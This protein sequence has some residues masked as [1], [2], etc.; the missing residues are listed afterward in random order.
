MNSSN[1]YIAYYRVSTVQQGKSGLGLQAQ[2]QTVRTY[3]QNDME[4]IIAEFTDIESGKNSS[5]PELM[6]ALSM[7]KE[8]NA[9]LVVAKLDRLSRELHFITEIQK[10]GIEFVCADMPEANSLTLHIFGA[11]AQH[12]R[13]LISKRTKDALAQAKL[14]GK[15]LGAA[16][17]KI[18]EALRNANPKGANHPQVK[19]ADRFAK[20]VS[21]HIMPLVELGIPQRKI[22]ETLNRH[23]V[24]TA[25]GGTWTL[26]Q[27]QRVLTRIKAM[28]AKEQ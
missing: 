19:A 4:H 25:R 20:E 9:I 8:E 12:E 21:I 15:K 11:V 7:A 3:L 2:K 16:N 26:C 27:L 10:S 28:K 23:K 6:K 17:P 13:E 5:R 18:Y 22:V 1:K 14:K 24:P